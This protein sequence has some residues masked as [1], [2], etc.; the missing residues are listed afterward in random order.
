MFLLVEET[1]RR[2]LE[3][4]DAIFAVKKARFVRYQVLEYLPWFFR[5]YVLG[6][7]DVPEPELYLDLIW[8]SGGSSDSVVGRDVGVGGF[9]ADGDGDGGRERDGHKV[10]SRWR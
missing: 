7:R 10:A 8:G 1:K 3:E 5:R 9:N 2:S 6:R 4:L